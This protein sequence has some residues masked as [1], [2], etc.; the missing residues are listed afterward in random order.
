MGGGASLL[1]L[2]S[3]KRSD[4]RRK[5][6]R[7]EGQQQQSKKKRKKRTPSPPHGAAGG[8]TKVDYPYWSRLVICVSGPSMCGRSTYHIMPTWLEMYK[9][10][11][12]GRSE[13]S[14]SLCLRDMKVRRKHLRLL[15]IGLDHSDLSDGLLPSGMLL[16]K[17]HKGKPCKLRLGGGGGGQRGGVG[18]GGGGARR[19]RIGDIFCVGLTQVRVAALSA[20]EA[21]FIEW[22]QRCSAE[23]SYR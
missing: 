20:A 2:S 22:R 14:C 10:P 1:L 3:S 11:T 5:R 19:L 7:G 8:K 4:E 6:N 9:R 21:V 23:Y 12:I 16:V 15:P 17:P 13:R 18:G